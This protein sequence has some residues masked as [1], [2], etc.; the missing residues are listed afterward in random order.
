MGTSFQFPALPSTRN[1][2]VL[3]IEDNPGD[4]RLIQQ[5]LSEP[6]E[7]DLQLTTRSRLSEALRVLQSAPPDIVLLDLGLPDAYGLEA[8]DAVRILAEE[9]PVVVLT[10]LDDERLAHRAIAQGAQDYLVKGRFNA[11]ILLRAMRY[12]LDRQQREVALRASE[13]RNRRLL[14]ACLIG[15][16]WTDSEGRILEANQAFLDLLGCSPEAITGG[17]VQWDGLVIEGDLD[18]HRAAFAEIE[19]GRRNSPWEVEIR[20]MDGSPIPVLL[21]ASRMEDPNLGLVVYALDTTERKAK[22]DQFRREARQDV[23]TGLR[24]RRA[25]LELLEPAMIASQRHGHPLSLA[26]CDL[27][28]FKDIND[29]HGHASGDDVLRAFGDLLAQEIRG[30]DVPA[31][32]GGDEF[33]ILYAHSPSHL[34]TRSLTRVRTAFEQREFL[35][36]KGIPFRSTAT[37]GLVDLPPGVKSPEGLLQLAD[38]ALYRAKRAGKN[39]IEIA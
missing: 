30:D 2:G 6:T 10:S 24:N 34:A 12:A 27:D 31:R 22:L 28:Q 25:F 26:L 4:I 38:E 23:L 7:L 14:E 17:E 33:C 32:L 11:D 36:P 29:R 18:R 9:T 3:L 19:S 21:G 16:A 8:M 35:D 20:R 39:R 15:L 13:A 1:L 5:M 37:F